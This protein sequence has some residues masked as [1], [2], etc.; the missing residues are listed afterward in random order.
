MSKPDNI[1][2]DVWEAAIKVE[3]DRP[4]HVRGYIGDIPNEAAVLPVALAILED[5][6][7]RG[8]APVSFVG[9]VSTLF[10]YGS[11]GIVKLDQPVRDRHYAV[12]NGQTKGRLALHPLRAGVRVCG[13]GMLG[14]EA[15][16][17]SDVAPAEPA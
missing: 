10:R 3:L 12:I 15:V 9:T 4:S 1:P 8:D 17:A 6:V 11:G 13:V 14:P 7:K 16:M 2:E 5:R